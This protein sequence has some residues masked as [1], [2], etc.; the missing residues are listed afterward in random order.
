MG[1]VRTHTRRT[2]RINPRGV[3]KVTAAHYGF[4]SSAEG[5][6]FIPEQKMYGAFD[7]DLVEIAPLP[8]KGAQKRS[9]SPSSA[10]HSALG[11]KPVA[12]V[13]RV[14][15]RAHEVIVGRYEVAE[16]F[17]VVIPADA[18]IPYDIFTMRR[19]SPDV[20]DG[21]LV[22]VRI[23]TYPSR[24]EAATGVI[25]EVLGTADDAHTSVEALI[26][27]HKLETHFSDAA[28]AEAESC[29]LD[30]TGALLSGYRDLRDRMV[31]TIDPADARDFDDALSLAEVT[32][33]HL[34]AHYRVGVHIADVSHYVPWGS[35]VDLDARRRATSVYL[36][37][38][39]IPML[40]EALSNGLCSLN[41]GEVRR[42]MTV[43]L[44]LDE[45]AK[46][47]DYEIYPAL[48]QSKRRFTY[49][50]VQDLLD[51]LHARG[52]FA[53]G[54]H[55]GIDFVE[56]CTKS[57]PVAEFAQTPVA[58][59]LPKD[60]SVN[61]G[62]LSSLTQKRIAMRQKAGGLEFEVPE[63]KVQLDEAG[64]PVGI[65]LRKKTE[66]TSLV[67]EFM[68]LANEA[69]AAYL[70]THDMPGI[71]RVHEKPLPERLAEL[72]PV[73]QE[74]SWSTE[75]DLEA[76]VAGN[77]HELQHVLACAKGRAEEQLVSA[78]LLRAQKRAVYSPRCEGHYGLASAA[79]CHF[80]SP[81]RRYPDLVVHRMLKASL[82]RKP[83]DFEQQTNALTWLSEHSS[84]MERVADKAARESQELK[85]VEYM[86]PHVGERFSAV[87]SGVANYGLYVQLENTVEGLVDVRILGQEYFSFD[88]VRRTL[89]GEQTGKSYRLGQ[90]VAVELLSADVR[91]STL[92]FKIVQA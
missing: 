38:R 70:M 32:S 33:G 23:S 7:G 26:A 76:F 20:S 11:E 61:L 88:E 2:P 52:P 15:E 3:L 10:G 55:D 56:D 86:A 49:D 84:A 18:R 72:V 19:D 40:P 24:R 67:E 41:P 77:P 57:I 43:D 45:Q 62:T 60:V 54:P 4:V 85:M 31:C 74:F 50:E 37:D 27:K 44:Y 83:S 87:V 13:V 65:K 89:T 9:S 82:L 17:G 79:Y 42:S 14:V 21:A 73:L 80:T 28:L 8:S 30:E 71:F 51:G 78:L 29:C 59:G 16:P 47:V 92:R 66:A 91:M 48:I 90:R 69:V 46:L 1:R 68:I 25:E 6:Y 53:H 35:S 63:A 22:R 64:K 39:V 34:G 5:D 36:V 81:I 75:V 58:C 12:R